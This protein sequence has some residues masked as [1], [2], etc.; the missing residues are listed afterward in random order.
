MGLCICS[1]SRGLYILVD[2]ILDNFVDC[3]IPFA[4]RS[5]VF[6]TSQGSEFAGHDCVCV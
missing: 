1:D 4:T 3:T 5:K 6:Q 2:F